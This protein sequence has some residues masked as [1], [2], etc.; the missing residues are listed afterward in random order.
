MLQTWERHAVELLVS[1]SLP[2]E[3]GCR[4]DF[5]ASRPFARC[6]LVSK[7]LVSGTASLQLLPEKYNRHSFY[8]R[9]KQ[10]IRHFICGAE[11]GHVLH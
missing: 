1:L 2:R 11:L 5:W 7:R 4:L 6:A 8:S 10:L 9:F 3:G